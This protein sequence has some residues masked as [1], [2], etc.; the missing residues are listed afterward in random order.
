MVEITNE[1]LKLVLSNNDYM[2]FGSRKGKKLE[3]NIYHGCCTSGP[4]GWYKQAGVD[5]YWWNEQPV[6]FENS[7]DRLEKCGFI[8]VWHGTLKEINTLN[9]NN[10]RPGDVATLYTG[11]SG[12]QHGLMWTGH[13]W[14]SDCI[15]KQADCYN[16]NGNQGDWGA[17][18]WRHPDFQQQEWGDIKDMKGGPG[19]VSFEGDNHNQS[20]DEKT[21]TD[22][23]TYSTSQTWKPREIMESRG[24][25]TLYTLSSG[26]EEK[27]NV[28]KLNEDMRNKYST[29]ADELISTS[30]ELGRNI[31]KCEEMYDSSILK[32][33][34]YSKLQRT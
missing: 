27:S 22:G 29:L 14:R 26:G 11:R 12:H 30:P 4:T 17:V 18:I 15:Q 28:I 8:P 9:E 10:L 6:T 21:Y 5:L 33:K 32:N 24:S 7:H 13:D 34:Q 1:K 31:I 16:G 2:L 25:N 23:T 3:Y 20:V 19:S